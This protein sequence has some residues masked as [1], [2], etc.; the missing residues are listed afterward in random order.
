M[1]FP[2]HISHYRFRSFLSSILAL[3]F[4][5][6]GGDIAEAK[7][8]G[9][10][11][12]YTKKGTASELRVVQRRGPDYL[13][14][15]GASYYVQETTDIVVNGNSKATFEEIEEGM[16]VSIAARVKDFARE[17]GEKNSYIATRIV[18]RTNQKATEDNKKGKSKKGK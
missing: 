16:Q 15:N 9:K 11:G 5:L 14:V 1:M 10:K 2:I 17:K 8:K 18:A 3:S 4:I 6:A 13:E 12:G 7:K